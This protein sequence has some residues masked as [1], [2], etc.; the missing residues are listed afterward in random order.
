[1][2]DI[3]SPV[4]NVAI[5]K[6]LLELDFSFRMNFQD[7]IKEAKL[8]THKCQ[9]LCYERKNSLLDAENC[10][11]NCYKPLLHAK[12][13]ISILIENLKENFEKCKFTAETGNKDLVGSRKEVKKCLNKYK[14]DLDGIKD[15]AEYIYKGYMK[16]F[17]S[18]IAEVE[19]VKI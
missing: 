3:N 17:D 13:N 18:L 1:M 16:N 15:E 10:A 11:R 14:T 4:N 12:K 6:I 5:E 7:L 2:I 8:L 9:Y 19:N